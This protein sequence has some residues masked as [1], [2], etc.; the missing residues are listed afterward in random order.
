[1]GLVQKMFGA[2]EHLFAKGDSTTEGYLLC[3]GTVNLHRDDCDDASAVT[4]VSMKDAVL[5]GDM[6]LLGLASTRDA[7][8]TAVTDCYVRIIFADTLR[9]V[10]DKFPSESWVFRDCLINS[11]MNSPDMDFEPL[12]QLARQSSQQHHNIH[13]HNVHGPVFTCCL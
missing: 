3:K 10:L 5:F 13:T 4:V 6:S 7:T 11:A 9:A 2:G 8:I 12:K 1:V